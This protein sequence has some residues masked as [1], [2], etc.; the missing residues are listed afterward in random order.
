[1]NILSFK[2]LSRIVSLSLAALLI[3]AV[4]PLAPVKAESLSELQ[5]QQ[6]SLEYQAQKAQEL[7]EANKTVAQ[8]ANERLQNVSGQINGLQG[9]IESTQSQISST[10]AQIKEKNQQVAKLESQLQSTKVQQNSLI[11]ELYISMLSRPS[12]LALFS[13]EPLSVKQERD[14]QLTTLKK[15]TE[16]LIADAQKAKD[17]T[18]KKIADLA[19]K[20]QSLE[21]LRGQQ[22]EQRDGLASMKN[23]Q[24]ALVNNAVS[25]QIAYESKA[26]SAKAQA[27][28]V[29]E[30]IRVLQLTVNWGS[31]IVSSDGG[32][33]YYTQT[34][35]PAR[36]GGSYYSVNLYGC[37]I[38][39]VAMVSAY[40]GNHSIT[41][42]YMAYNAS[43]ADGAYYFNTP[44]NLPMSVRAG[45][46]VNWGVVQNE[47]S[48]G[49]PVIVSIYLSSVGA[50]NWDGSSHFV[51]IKGYENGHYLMQ[52][53]IGHG[54]SYNLNQVRSMYLTSRR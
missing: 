47:V 49:R 18:Q 38:T 40:Y 31:Q 7:A 48:A 22:T 19:V 8:R 29:A 26:N 9:A 44:G 6:A 14:N 53:P 3:L 27:A 21:S 17:E 45:G 12:D 2:N 25:A 54:R 15:A 32:G 20:Q 34:G 37:L 24:S 13:N 30:K 52:D 23:Q 4:T 50:L 36:M 5:R 43:F 1:M 33:W 10:S 39:S 35:N 42:T 41:P 46:S 11:R 16:Q 28:Q 51:V